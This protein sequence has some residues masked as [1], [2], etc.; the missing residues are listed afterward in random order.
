MLDGQFS[1]GWVVSGVNEEVGGDGVN[2]P[3][4]L[5]VDV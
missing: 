4:E 3:E 5:L 1:K 2:I